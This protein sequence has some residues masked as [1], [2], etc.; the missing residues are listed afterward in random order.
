MWHNYDD[1]K[2]VNSGDKIIFICDDGCSSIVAMLVDAGSNGETSILH[3]EDAMELNP[4]WLRGSI[5][6][7]IP[8]DYPIS[9]TQETVSDWF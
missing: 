4:E 7:K 5:W 6:T 3:A 1:E 9:F 8:D 2:P